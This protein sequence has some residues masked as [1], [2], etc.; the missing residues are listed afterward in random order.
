MN[1]A[2]ITPERA[3][4]GARI[5]F[6][7]ARQMGVLV[8]GILDFSHKETRLQPTRLNDVVKRT[9]EFITPQNKYERIAFELDLAEDLPEMSLDPAQI[10]QVLLNLFSN[11]ADAILAA[12]RTEPRI[13][14]RTR[15]TS[16][17]GVELAVEDNGPGIPAEALS[18]LFEPAFTTKPEGHGFGLSTCYRIV[19]NHG[20]SITAE[21]SPRAGARF[22]VVLPVR[23]A[24]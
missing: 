23:K 24:A 21:N 9:V 15:F 1:A 16:G 12:G 18:K 17:D 6:E 11:A 3:Q 14:V 2:T 8:K 19:K 22:T 4:D 7:Q 5:I 13:V 20:G 10:Q